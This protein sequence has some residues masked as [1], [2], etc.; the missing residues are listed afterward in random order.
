MPFAILTP[1]KADCSF[2]APRPSGARPRGIRPADLAHGLANVHALF[3]LRARELL[4]VVFV[5]I[6][7]VAIGAEMRQ[8]SADEAFPEDRNYRSLILAEVEID[9]AVRIAPRAS[10]RVEGQRMTLASQLESLTQGH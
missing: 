8:S 6:A 9:L 10:R 2:E 5:A 3:H 4:R 1:K 7:L